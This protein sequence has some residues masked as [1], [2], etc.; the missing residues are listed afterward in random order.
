MIRF[1]RIMLEQ[2]LLLVSIFCVTS[3]VFMF[4]LFVLLH[5]FYYEYNIYLAEMFPT[6]LLL[7][8][9]NTYLS[10]IPMMFAFSFL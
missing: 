9:N 3:V 1:T 6:F 10:L 5:I 2:F 8:I 4:L 7:N